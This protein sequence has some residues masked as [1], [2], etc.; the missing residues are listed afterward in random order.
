M[1]FANNFARKNNYNCI[2]LDVFSPSERARQLYENQEFREIGSFH[3][4]YQK[5]PYVCYEKLL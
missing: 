1:D 5:V 4:E 2:R 3:A